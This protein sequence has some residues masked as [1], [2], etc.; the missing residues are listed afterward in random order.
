MNHDIILV[1]R[2]QDKLEQLSAELKTKHNEI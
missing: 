1:A 2:R